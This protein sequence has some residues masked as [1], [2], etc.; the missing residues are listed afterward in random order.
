MK[1]DCSGSSKRVFQLKCVGVS[2]R[3]A[4][5]VVEGLLISI[6]VIK[7]RRVLLTFKHRYSQNSTKLTRNA[8]ILKN[9]A[10][11]IKPNATGN[12]NTKKCVKQDLNLGAKEAEI[13]QIKGMK[14]RGIT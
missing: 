9:E 2:P 7:F 13:T 6:S 14:D 5:I 10:I 4:K 3:D 11:V 1:L 8:N 12:S